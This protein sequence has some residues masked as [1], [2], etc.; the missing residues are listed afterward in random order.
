M[1][2]DN[3]S[4]PLYRI[5]DFSRVVQIFEKNELY[6]AK[7]NTWDDPYEQ[8]LKHSKDHA[9]FAQCW[10]QLGISDAMW[11]IYSQNGMG[12]R[13]STT[14]GKLTAV[15][16][17]ACREK[18]YR[19]RVRE[20]TYRSQK[21]LNFQTAKIVSELRES[22]DIRRAAD[23][24]YMKRDAFSHESEWRATLLALSEDRASEKKGLTIP[25]DP[26]AFIDRILLDPRAPDELVSAFQFY[27]KNKL[28]FKGLVQRSV[29]YK[30]PKCF[31]I[32]DD[33]ISIEDI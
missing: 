31:E 3:S 25:V 19:Y 8:R 9:L 32:D 11:R 2:V 21:S 7:P 5:M 16:K 15:L 10:C 14:V 1:A 28:K 20:V 29:L 33:S 6:F 23:I 30:A 26:H 24:L 22:F 13:I 4:K 17:S 12:V 27:F 18:E